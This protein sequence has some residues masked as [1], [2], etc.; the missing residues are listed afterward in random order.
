M[1]ALLPAFLMLTLAAPAAA[2]TVPPFELFAGY[3]LLPGDPIDDFPRV[4]ASHGLQIEAAANLT[5]WMS[6]FADAGVQW[7][8]HSL[9]GPPWEDQTAKTRVTELFAGPRFVA[10]SRNVRVFAHGLVGWV[11]GDAGEF[12]GFSDTRFGFGAGGGV[13]VPLRD[14]LAIRGQF[15][16]FASFTDIV[17]A[18]PRFAIGVVKGFGR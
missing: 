9:S 13:D 6:L 12:E 1:R 14:R 10:R 18:N 5:R 11:S 16:L 4:S 3:S 17:E 15:D 2:Q 8:R 7:G